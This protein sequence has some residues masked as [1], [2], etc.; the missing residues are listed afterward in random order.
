M[1]TKQ[2]TQDELETWNGKIQSGH[3]TIHE[4]IEGG[5]RGLKAWLMS[6]LAHIQTQV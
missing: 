4:C 1:K 3:E 5:G 6:V 2:T